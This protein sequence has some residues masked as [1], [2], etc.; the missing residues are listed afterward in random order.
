M[1]QPSLPTLDEILGTDV[2]LSCAK[3]KIL[4]LQEFPSINKSNL[5]LTQEIFLYNF[6]TSHV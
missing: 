2:V 1:A 6:S 5:G 3:K 4:P